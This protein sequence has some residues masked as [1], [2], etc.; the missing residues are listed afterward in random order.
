ML[1]CLILAFPC[2]PF[3]ILANER[4]VSPLGSSLPPFISWDTAATNIQDAIEASVAGDVVWVSNGVYAV[5]GKNIQGTQTNRVT[6]DKPI[7]VQS[8][9]GAS[10]TTI[11][12]AWDPASTNGPLSVRCASLTNGAI[13]RGFTLIGG[14]SPGGYHQGGGGA[15]GASTSAIVESCVITQNA[16]SD[17]GGGAYNLTLTN[18]TLSGN[19]C[20]GYSAMSGGGGAASCNLN[21][22]LISGNS[23]VKNNGGGTLNCNLRNCAVTRNLSSS[24]GGGVSY[25]TLVNCTVTGNQIPPHGGYGGGVY[26]ASLT[27][28]IV[29]ANQAPAGNSASNYLSCTLV[30]CCSLPLPSGIGNIGLD[31]QLVGDFHLGTNSPCLGA[32]TNLYASG[33]DMD[34]QPW[35]NPVSIGCDEWYPVPVI[36]A[37]PQAV[38]TNSPLALTFP[39]LLLAGQQPFTIWWNK[40]GTTLSDDSHYVGTSTASLLVKNFGPAD[41]GWYYATASNA[42]GVSTSAPVQVVVHCVDVSNIAPALPF[43][44]WSTA[45]T[46]IQ[47]GIDFSFDG[48]FVLVTNGLFAS[49]GKVI[50]GDFTNRIAVTRRLTVASING[51][52]ATVIEGN[53]DPATTNGP[54]AMRCAWLTDGA[55]LS[56]FTLTGGATGT[57]ATASGVFICG[58]GVFATSTNA[59][60]AN[61]VI[62]N[63]AA[64]TLGGGVMNATLERCRITSNRAGQRGGGAESALLLNCLVQGNSANTAG[65]VDY[66]TLVNCTVVRNHADQNTGGVLNSTAINSILFFNSDRYG[67]SSVSADGIFIPVSDISFS[68]IG[69]AV[70]WQGIG[71]I[72]NDPE[73]L[74]GVHLSATSRCRG[75]GNSI[76]SSGVDIDDEPWA[77]PPSMG[78]DEFYL[79]DCIG[80]LTVG[81]TSAQ[82][83]VVQGV[84]MFLY[85][86][87]NGRPSRVTWSFGDGATITNASP[88]SPWHVWSSPGNYEVTFTAFNLD[89]PNGVSTNVAVEV[90]PLIPPTIYGEELQGTNFSFTFGTQPGVEYFVEQTT[91]LSPPVLWQTVGLIVGTGL[92]AQAIDPLATNVARFY[93]VRSP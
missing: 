5:G 89:N 30:Y 35:A 92:P 67:P 41:A 77:N 24:Y 42:Y 73:L 53:Q 7:V 22:C 85:G 62:S 17:Q 45:A 64:A 37:Q 60:V 55:V 27:N 59:R 10:V 9:G 32:G 93:R 68:C 6:L 29:Y 82:S 13:L 11:Q 43:S 69:K 16:G 84:P 50:D 48:E 61:C 39:G 31:P 19:I 46:N 83:T 66:G 21:N 71:V 79:E 76:F 54:A 15:S 58:G 81:L 88:L 34:G 36:A 40:E 33:V 74:D 80:P 70:G 2:F 52:N 44:T 56:G 14:A 26:S 87:V 1:F 57:N 18:C 91:N 49:G 63:N 23:A 51:P 47:D 12:G 72:T 65:A 86:Q 78:C 4:F 75:A 8:V 90:L 38:V 25:G 3:S 20:L 28:C